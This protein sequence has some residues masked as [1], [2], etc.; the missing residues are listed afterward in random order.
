A[1]SDDPT[2]PATSLSTEGVGVAE[3]ER[4]IALL[5]GENARLTVD[6]ARARHVGEERARE[7][8]GAARRKSE[9]LANFSHEIRTPLNGIIGYCD[10]LA[11]EE[12]SR[13]TPH[14]RR[15]LQV[16]KA[17]AKTLLALINDI[18]DLSKIESGHIEI[19]REEV[20][21]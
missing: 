1:V 20:D 13:L 9:L 6:L 11:R 19:V 8:E 10:L 16:V 21:V 4:R 12:G 2:A 3:L 17:N 14:G 5:E 7:I 15:D 18:L